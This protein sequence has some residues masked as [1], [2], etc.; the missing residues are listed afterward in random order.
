MWEQVEVYL[1]NHLASTSTNNYPYK[2]NISTI[3]I[4]L[5]Y[6]NE[7]KETQVEIDWEHP[8]DTPG[9]PGHASG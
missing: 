2:A 9:Q 6:G 3:E 7:A 8:G 5:Q 1:N 4:L